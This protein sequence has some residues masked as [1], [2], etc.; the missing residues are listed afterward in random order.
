MRGGLLVAVL[1]AAPCA[2][3]A[4]DGDKGYFQ[5]SLSLHGLSEHARG[6]AYVGP[7]AGPRRDLAAA[8][9]LGL[10]A[11]VRLPGGWLQAS[12]FSLAHDPLSE[13]N[14]GIF[15][16][17]RARGST[18]LGGRWHL[19]FDDSARLQRRES[20]GLADFERNDAVLGLERLLDSGAAVGF[21]AGDRRRSV[22]GAPLLAFDR[23]S[24]AVSATW[25]RAG[26]SQW[27]VEAGPQR[28]STD[29]ARGWRLA[30]AGEWAGRAAGWNGAV[31]VTW[32]EPWNGIGGRDSAA[33]DASLMTPVP[34]ASATAAPPAAPVPQPTPAPPPMPPPVADTP[35]AE[36]R[37]VAAIHEPLLGPS[38]IVDPLEDDE[39][40][41]DFGRRKREIV[42]FVSRAIG[43]RLL[44]T[45]EMRADIER[46]PD[47]L[48][49]FAGDVRRQRVAA[50]LHLKRE[51]GTRWSV[52]AQAGWQHLDDNRP[53]LGY[54]RGLFSIGVEL[55]P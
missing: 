44:L 39:S 20:G 31:R 42:A 41:W 52:L 32:L 28:F 17:A 27:R 33:A 48:G 25:G 51:L 9:G 36:P 12:G 15:A 6:P 54:S 23:Q 46:G 11:R 13:D 14:R 22:G 24:I 5:P 53:R 7:N 2:G 37:M 47:L 10:D 3:R 45:A 29:R 1:L 18:A 50:R 49:T 35:A 55:R 34:S 16:A 21:R 8:F 38:L 4:Q 43:A 40:D 26:G 19:R 30:A